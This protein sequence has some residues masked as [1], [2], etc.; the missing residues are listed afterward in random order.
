MNMRGSVVH[1]ASGLAIL[2]SA[3]Q[4]YIGL[5]M[6][7]FGTGGLHTHITFAILLLIL[8][9]IPFLRGE[10]IVKKMYLGLIGLLIIQGIIG[11][12]MA[13]IQHIGALEMIH[14]L[15]GWLILLGS[16]GGLT[17]LFLRK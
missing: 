11:L 3:L 10:S 14:H 5:N 16:L 17:I 8:F 9:H 13:F 1:I 15:I 12:Y 2:F 6:D 4:V 7:S